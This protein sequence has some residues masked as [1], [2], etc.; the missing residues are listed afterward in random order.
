LEGAVKAII[1][2]PLINALGNDASGAFQPEARA[3]AKLHG[4]DQSNVHLFDNRA[5]MA[6]RRAQVASWMNK[7]DG[8]D[9]FA[10]FCHGCP[11][12]VQAGWE[13][14]VIWQMAEAIKAA[15]THAPTVVLY[16]C[17]TGADTDADTA[18]EDC[19]G[20]GGEGGF[21]D[22]LRHELVKVGVKAT[23]Y[24]HATRGHTTQNPRVRRFLPDQAAGGEWVIAPHSEH[25]PAWAHA[26]R[27]TDLRF[28]F[29][30]MTQADIESELRASIHHVAE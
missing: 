5:P 4:V 27:D 11:T 13:I 9:T 3:F 2:A 29:P 16:C 25:W 24:A 30:F 18:D 14:G 19:N 6:A 26:L 20:P 17:S 15:C 7:A 28:R 8:A 1:F 12:G 22:A 10:L 23:I 21:A